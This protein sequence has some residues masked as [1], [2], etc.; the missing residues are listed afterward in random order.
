MFDLRLLG[1]SRHLLVSDMARHLL[2]WAYLS[3]AIVALSGFLMFA[4]DAS[5]IATNPAFRL[6]LILIAATSVNAAVFHGG[7]YRSVKL[8]NRGVKAP[9]TARITAIFSL[10]LWT[11]VI[12]CGRL[13]AYV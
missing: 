2:P 11:A 6:K 7:I 10:I 1:F 12:V 5:V 9:A 3:F 8:W 4:V 13:I